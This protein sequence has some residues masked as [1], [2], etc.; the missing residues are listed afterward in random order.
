MTST[1][2]GGSR[3]SI[4]L[5]CVEVELPHPTDSMHLGGLVSIPFALTK[6]SATWFELTTIASY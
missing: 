4:G 1:R 3:V 5:L 2:R 6:G